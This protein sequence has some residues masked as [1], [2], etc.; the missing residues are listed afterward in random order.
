MYP[1][2]QGNISDVSLHFPL[3]HP[4]KVVHLLFDSESVLILNY[5]EKNVQNLTNQIAFY[6]LD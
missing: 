3:I 5:T 1:C 6:G 4:R 2:F